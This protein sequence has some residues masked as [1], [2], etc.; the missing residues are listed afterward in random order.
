MTSNSK[1]PIEI[2]PWFKGF[3]VTFLLFIIS[4]V[5]DYIWDLYSKNELLVNMRGGRLEYAD[6]LFFYMSGLLAAGK[7][8]LHFYDPAI[9]MGYF[10]GLLSPYSVAKPVILHQVPF[11]SVI[12]LPCVLMSPAHAYLVWFAL[13]VALSAV[14]FAFWC[15]RC[16]NLTRWEGLIVYLHLMASYPSLVGLRMGQQAWNIASFLNLY[17]VGLYKRF[18]LLGGITLALLTQKPHYVL[19]FCLPAFFNK[20]FKLLLYASVFEIILLASAV[21]KIGWDN[22]IG[23]PQIVLHADSS[24]DFLGI[25]SYKMVCLRGLL[26]LYLTPALALK[27]GLYSMVGGLLLANW[28]WF[29]TV[30]AKMTTFYQQRWALAAT[31][32]LCV[33]CSPHTHGYDLLLL[34]PLALTV[35]TKTNQPSDG[36]SIEETEPASIVYLLWRLIL[37][38]YPLGTWI[39]IIGGGLLK[40]SPFTTMFAVNVILAGLAIKLW[41][42]QLKR[43]QAAGS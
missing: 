35:F 43:I 5:A 13:T 37:S 28:I 22:V 40:I 24:E 19:F 26:S 17:L 14:A 15:K 42:N 25:D 36:E 29:K 2:R 34:T 23:Y 3:H 32:T 8:A 33:I 27:A 21:C 1:K 6:F 41:S 7:D 18:D 12:M 20:R 30:R 10:N 9:Q 11:V 16:T 39:I 38:A 31:L 4:A